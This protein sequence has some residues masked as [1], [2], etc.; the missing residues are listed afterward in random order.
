MDSAQ[1]T[2]FKLLALKFMV[3]IALV[4]GALS[5]SSAIASEPSCT[6]AFGAE[7]KLLTASARLA[8]NKRDYLDKF[9]LSLPQEGSF[10][11]VADANGW[12]KQVDGFWGTY[13]DNFSPAPGGFATGASGIADAELQLAS[14]TDSRAENVLATA[15]DNDE[16]YFSYTALKMVAGLHRV[17]ACMAAR[18]ASAPAAPPARSASASD[19]TK[20]RESCLQQA[21]SSWNFTA[22]GE[23]SLRSYTL[24]RISFEI[25]QVR[26][27]AG[28]EGLAL[29]NKYLNAADAQLS[30]ADQ[31][32]KIRSNPQAIREFANLVARFA[33]PYRGS[34]AGVGRTYEACI[35]N[36][37]AAQL[38]RG[39]TGTITKS[40]PTAP[41]TRR[42]QPQPAPAS[43]QPPIAVQQP[44]VPIA[45]A[46]ADV[47]AA[48]AAVTAKPGVF[49]K[50]AD[51]ALAV[52]SSTE[53]HRDQA[54]ARLIANEVAAIEKKYPVTQCADSEDRIA[55]AACLKVRNE[56]LFKRAEAEIAYLD[57]M[58]PNITNA[59][60]NS[61]KAKF[62]LGASL[63][64][65][66]C[67]K[68]TGSTAPC[69]LSA[70]S[71]SR[72][73]LPSRVIARD[74]RNALDCVKLVDL[75]QANSSTSGSGRVLAN[76]C[77]DTV[78]IGWCST[79][80][81]CERGA[82]NQTTV[83]A[84]HSWPVDR[85][86][87][88]RWGACHGANTLHGDPGSKGLQFTCSAPYK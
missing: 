48:A 3:P 45:R 70:G 83:L 66:S 35:A 60:Y 75:A 61:D 39:A 59:L 32:A 71:A 29:R 24:E 38:E 27:N 30:T 88:V 47:A 73:N 14:Q 11:Q 68:L 22:D 84:G 67:A 8:R 16:N 42:V 53:L 50:Y 26:F 64:R 87:E 13:M 85:N 52:R 49:D 78:E 17:R 69:D 2:E 5:P 34:A 55:F 82:G 58:R 63:A 80:G 76:Q 74:G 37:E 81:E 21:R 65:D 4:L 18:S 19:L 28:P 72:P 23:A 41:P 33:A 43:P 44:P 62:E 40:A 7:M 6:G 57:G 10:P 86:H 15:Q 77:T 79:G 54:M 51:D 12:Q 9:L 36:A 20:D 31:A 56:A 1:C 25:V 46:A